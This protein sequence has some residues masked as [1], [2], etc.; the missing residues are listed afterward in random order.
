MGIS[1]CNQRYLQPGTRDT[2]VTACH[3]CGVIAI[4]NRIIKEDFSA[5]EHKGQTLMPNKAHTNI[6]VGVLNFS[7]R[8][9]CLLLISFR[10]LVVA[11][12]FRPN[13]CGEVTSGPLNSVVAGSES[14][15]G[16]RRS[17]YGRFSWFFLTCKMFTNQLPLKVFYKNF[18][19][20]ATPRSRNG[21]L[22]H[23]QPF[24]L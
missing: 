20:I 5:S 19:I 16:C 9:Q 8:A 1:R 3:S 18:K 14:A 6:A 22:I 21:C 10:W 17:V 23:S 13:R 15:A 2:I 24:L 4:I 12:M 7:H 11:K